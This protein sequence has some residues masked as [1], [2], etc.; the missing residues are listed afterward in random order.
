MEKTENF[1]LFLGEGKFIAETI[2]PL[3]DGIFPKLHEFQ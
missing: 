2:G 3:I 1:L